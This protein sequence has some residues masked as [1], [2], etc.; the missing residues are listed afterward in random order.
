MLRDHVCKQLS[1]E[2]TQSV[3]SVTEAGVELLSLPGALTA[4]A[5]DGQVLCQACSQRSPL[6][7]TLQLVPGSKSV[8]LNLIF[9]DLLV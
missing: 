6:K 7:L 9:T 2:L 4:Q 5:T 1:P 8:T 3:D